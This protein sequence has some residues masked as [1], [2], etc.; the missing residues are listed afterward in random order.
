MDQGVR[1]LSPA[2]FAIVMATGVISIAAHL[3]GLRLI[4]VTLFFFNV[5]AYPILWLLTL[6]RLVRCP[7]ETFRDLIDHVRGPGF[8]TA[9]AATGVLGSQLVVMWRWFEPA[10]A[11]WFLG[12]ALW[13][14]LTYS[15]FTGFIIKEDKPTLAEGITGAW[16]IAVV[17]TQSIAVLGVYIAA[18]FEQ[19][20][21]LHVNFVALSMWL[22]GGMLYIWMIS[23]IFY[24]YTF[25][26]FS[27]GDLTPPYWINMGA[28]AIST[29][30]G[31][32]L[33]INTPE[34]PFL[35]SLLPFLEGFTIFYW[36]TGTW[37][38]PMLVVLMFWR[39]VVKR[40]PLSYDPLYWGAVF[41]L[42]MYTVATYQMAQAM[43][44][45]F[46]LIFPRCFLYVA[47]VAWLATFIGLVRRLATCLLAIFQPAPEATSPVPPTRETEESE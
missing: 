36:A 30:G 11:L 33:I 34:A 32:L 17:A 44:L 45:K 38:I 2:Y 15:I 18:H 5:V 1:N 43:H 23:L 8:L 3:H 16:L 6:L 37:W 40:F 41:P 46:L 26:K 20:H 27:P 19:P 31:S 42:G 10:V 22:W 9:V 35:Q 21:R 47:L 39:H 13:I 24:R 12:I 28:M 25:F 4:A 7:R 14:A 29:L